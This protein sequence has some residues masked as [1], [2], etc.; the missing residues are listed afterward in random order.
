MRDRPAVPLD[1]VVALDKFRGSLTAVEACDALARGLERAGVRAHRLPVAD[2]GEGTVAAVVS[3][4]AAAVS[5]RVTGPDG[6]PVGAAFAVRDGRAVVELAQASGLQLLGDRPRP[7]TAGT[8]GTGELVRAALD[9]G[10]RSIVLGVGGSASTDGGAG[11]LTALG[12]RLL[13]SSGRELP[14]GGAALRDLDRLDLTGLDRR[15][16]D[17]AVTLASDVDN[18][19]LGPSGAAA[20]FGPQKGAGPDDVAVLEAGLSRWAA[21]LASAVGRDLSGA[22]GA[23]AAGGTGLAALAVLGAGRRAGIDVVLDE[24]GADAVLAEAGVV[25]VGEGRL[26]DSSLQGK[27]PVGVARRTPPGVPV[28]AVSGEC[29]VG[30]ERLRA[31]GLEPGPTLVEAAG[32]DRARAIREAVVLLEAVGERLAG[33]LPYGRQT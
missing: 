20:V 19:L 3:A 26:D 23:G 21:V 15:L 31:A 4:G 1:V 28:V 33:D 9:L 25:V 7:L 17:C 11:M 18:P 24:L 27:A 8:A 22:E 10:C 16:A 13:D 29:L 14:S 6:A 2:G 12:A 32:G 5:R 30:P